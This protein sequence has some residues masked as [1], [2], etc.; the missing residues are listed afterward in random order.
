MEMNLSRQQVALVLTTK[1]TTTKKK[2]RSKNKT[3]RNL[4]EADPS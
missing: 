1:L 2:N 3:K 4:R